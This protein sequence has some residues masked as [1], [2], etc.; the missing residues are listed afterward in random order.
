MVGRTFGKSFVVCMLCLSLL[1]SPALACSW[2][3]F[4]NGTA[5][6]VGRTMDWYSSDGAVVKGHG[7]NVAVKAA[8]TPDALEYTAK[9]ASLQVH[10]FDSGIVIEGMNEKGLQASILFLDGSKLPASQPDRKD[11]APTR[12]I[13]YVLSNFATVREVVDSLDT[14]NIV[15]ATMDIPGA[16][17]Q[18]IDYAPEDWP[19][20]F[21]IADTGG[22]K[23][24]IEFVKGEIKIYHGREHDAM[25]NEPDYEMQRAIEELGYQPNGSI[26]TVDRRLR[27][28]SYLK[29]MYERGVKDP[30][31]A[32]IAMRGLVASVNAG[33]EQIDRQEN[34]V[35]PTLWSVLADQT[36]KT[37]YLTRTDSWCSEIYDFSMFDSDKPV[38]VA[39]SPADCPYPA[40][41]SRDGQ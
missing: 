11:V 26:A 31:R 23:A 13:D 12:F 17:G 29:D 14:I 40:L 30:Q 41:G 32:L 6:V 25:T 8:D 33:T 1:P 2:A 22:D 7:R 24:I 37:Y 39:L 36:N 34:E 21:A 20:H 3:A 35:Y 9:Y 38:V 5:A 16:E 19:G 27:A 28:R 4:A 18:A 10:S 15:P